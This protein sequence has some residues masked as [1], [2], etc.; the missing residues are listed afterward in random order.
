[1]RAIKTHELTPE[2]IQAMG[3][4]D[5]LY[6]YNGLDC[7]VTAKVYEGLRAECDNTTLATYDFSKSL[8]GPILEINLH[9]LLVDEPV[10]L[11]KVNDLR[12]K[13]KRLEKQLDRLLDEG[14]GV[15]GLNWRSPPQLKKLFYEVMGL[16][17][18]RKRG[19]NG[20]VETVDR[21]ALEKLSNYFYVELI[22]NHLL[23]MRD[24]GKK[25]SVLE[26][27]IDDDGRFR[28]STNIAGTS[29]GR[30]SSSYSETGTGGNLQNIE[31]QLRQIFI[32]DPGMKF[33]YI[34]LEQAE[35]RGVGAIEWN[36]FKDGKYLDAC[37]SGDLHTSVCKLAWSSLPWLGDLKADKEI[38]ERPFYRQHSY[39]HMAKVLG[40]GTNYAGQP[41][42]M[43]KHTKLDASIIK[44]FQAKYFTAFPSH[45]Q[46]HEWVASA[47]GADGKLT[48][49]MG[50][51]RYFWGR[52]NDPSTIREA[53]A[54]EP[55]SMVADILNRG[56]LKVWRLGICQLMLQIHDAILIQYPEDQEDQILPRVLKEIIVPVELLHG[57]KLIIPSEALT[58]WNWA[59]WTKDNPNGLQKYRG[60]DGRKRIAST[61][62]DILDRDIH[63]IY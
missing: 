1:M 55:Q 44:E 51:K 60:R 34:D 21:D 61:K 31:E 4:S 38:A 15:P 7:C 20:M 35:S 13:I 48:T 39:R 28:N 14:L 24:L 9:G 54:F 8:Q 58:G 22:V 3:V 45:L 25:I 23:L 6:V 62:V 2:A 43:A 41:Y 10:R 53:I 40:H 27:D 18:V 42:T 37:E 52:R 11:A 26:T 50:R 12:T 29:T 36:L 5:R 19:A 33:A 32:S 30:L 59:K 46:W 63:S 16:P 57:R 56:M 47:L 49:I 17:P